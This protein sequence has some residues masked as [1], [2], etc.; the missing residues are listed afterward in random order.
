[1]VIDEGIQLSNKSL[2]LIIDVQK[3]FDDPR[4][5]R[6]NNPD[7]ETNVSR[8]IQHWR[9]HSLPLVFFKH[10]SRNPDSPLFPGKEGNKIK[11]V[12]L[13]KNDEVVMEKS[14]NSCFIGTKLDSWIRSRNI[15]TIFMAG[16]TAEHCVSTTARMSANMGYTTVVVPDATASFESRG[17]NGE[18]ISPE[19]VHQVS[20]ATINGE[21]ARLIRTYDVLS[22]KVIGKV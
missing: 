10:N 4:W 5:G 8:L 18:V 11:E 1:M 21:F 20:L 3:G 12:A 7:A 19:V 14:V 16:L 15:D 6:R 2:L 13:P 22:L 17:I 9:K